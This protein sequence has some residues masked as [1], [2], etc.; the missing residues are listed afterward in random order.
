M[1]LKVLL[2]NGPRTPSSTRPPLHT[3]PTSTRNSHNWDEK[4]G[5]PLLS[6]RQINMACSPESSLSTLNDSYYYVP[7]PKQRKILEINSPGSKKSTRTPPRIPKISLTPRSDRLSAYSN[8]D[9]INNEFPSPP[10]GLPTDNDLTGESQRILQRAYE[11]ESSIALTERSGSLQAPPSRPSSF[12][13]LPDWGEPNSSSWFS[14]P[15]PGIGFQEGFLDSTSLSDDDLNDEM[16][17]LASPAVIAE[18]KNPQSSLKHRRLRPVAE[19]TGHLST[20]SLLGINF[21]SS[22]TCLATMEGKPSTGSFP[23]Q[24]RFPNKPSSPSGAQPQRNESHSPVG[25]TLDSVQPMSSERDLVTPP[26]L[27]QL[28]EPP[29]LSPHVGHDNQH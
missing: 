18:E 16:F 11:Q 22:S 4:E 24:C 27:P 23:L 29:A 2:H 5:S 21:I 13:P 19:S 10:R 12:I 1:P 9:G 28:K 25:L 6:V 26:T 17:V 3:T 15:N 14:D 7:S 8:S 20:T